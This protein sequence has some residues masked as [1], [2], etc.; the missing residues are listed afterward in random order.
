MLLVGGA[1]A[2]IWVLLGRR[3]RIGFSHVSVI[4]S[5]SSLKLL[6]HCGAFFVIFRRHVGSRELLEWIAMASR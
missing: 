6:G 4:P 2:E 1:K 3:V 5:G